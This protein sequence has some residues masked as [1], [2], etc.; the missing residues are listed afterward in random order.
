MNELTM[1]LFVV[2][3][4]LFVIAYIVKV[5]AI[6]WLTF[7]TSICSIGQTV[8]DLAVDD[9][10]LVIMMMPLIYVMF[11]SGWSAFAGNSK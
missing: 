5:E 7:F 11:M 1:V 10:E 4:A 8:S 6:N 2:T 3:L 9:T